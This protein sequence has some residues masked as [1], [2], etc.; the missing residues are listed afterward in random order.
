M[1]SPSSQQQPSLNLISSR[2]FESRNQAI[3]EPLPTQVNAPAGSLNAD[4][5][6]D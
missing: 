1:D 5:Q 2:N 4:P 6:A 3:V